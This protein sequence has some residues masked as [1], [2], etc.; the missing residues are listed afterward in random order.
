MVNYATQWIHQNNEIDL[1]E[2]YFA[3]ESPE[4]LSESITTKTL[5]IFKDPNPIKRAATK[6]AWHPETSEM[7]V[8]VSYAMLRFQQMPQD[9]PRESYIW[10]LNNPNFPEKTLL[11]PSPLC[12]MQFNHKNSDFV[13]GG[14]YNGSLSFFDTRQ[15]NSQGVVKPFRTTILEKSHHDPVY[16]VD[17][18]TVGKSGNECVSTSTDG[19]ILW[20]DMRSAENQPIES[21]SL[22]EKIPV[23]DDFKTK[24]LG[25][26]A[27]CYNA[28]AGP[29]KYL[30]GTEQGY[31]LQANKRKTIEVQQRFGYDSGKHH[32]PIYA[33]K[34]N[35]GHVKYFLS[36]GDWSAKVWSEELKAPI[37]QTRYH[38][39]YL[40]D[41]CWSPTRCGLFFLTRIDGFL[42]VWDFFYRQ[43][44]VAYSQKISDSPLTSISVNQNMAAIGDA[45]GTVSIMQLCP[46]LYDTTPKEKE[47]M[48]TIFEREFKRE[49]NLEVAKKLAN[50]AATK[51]SKQPK[52]SAES[53]AAEKEKKLKAKLESIENDFFKAVSVDDDLE[54]IKARGS[55]AMAAEEEPIAKQA[56]GKSEE[57]KQ[58]V[59]LVDG[60]KYTLE[61]SGDGNGKISFDAEA[62]GVIGTADANGSISAGKIVLTAFNREFEGVFSSGTSANL[63]WKQVDKPDVTGTAVATLTKL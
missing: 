29:L 26:T 9:M 14:S 54:A 39:A 8:G 33:L 51:Q 58:A 40:T 36:V 28:D 41:G 12:C 17:W 16:D 49:K 55:M 15:G 35:P 3:G 25:G 50:D 56:T 62:G 4:H 1:F 34:R 5:M 20:W 59:D 2:E 38:S 61:I 10:N 52:Q 22:E 57:K 42:D 48:Q 13:V 44:E 21:L 43:N 7:R 46:P 30:I 23:G 45:E 37:M 6:I 32:G 63:T 27:L 60:A 47:V 19:R 31:V 24:L 53:L 18:I 11:A